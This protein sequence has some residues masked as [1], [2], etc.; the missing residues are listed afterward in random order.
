MKNPHNSYIAILAFGHERL[1]GKVY[2]WL[3][4]YE[5]KYE[6]NYHVEVDHGSSVETVYNGKSLDEAKKAYDEEIARWSEY[7]KPHLVDLE[8]D[9]DDDDAGDA[10]QLLA[11]LENI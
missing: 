9:D 1:Q 10:E 2:V 4:K 8:A 5:D 7:Y 6:T 11:D 3:R